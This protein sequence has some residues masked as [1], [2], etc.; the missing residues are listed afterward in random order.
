MHFREDVWLCMCGS[1]CVVLI[2]IIIIII[3]FAD[4][5]LRRS[6]RNV[7]TRNSVG[8]SVWN[9]Y[10]VIIIIIMIIIIIIWLLLFYNYNNNNI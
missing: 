5:G 9:S 10:S 1:V 4:E 3:I 8:W 7:L 2:I 6:D